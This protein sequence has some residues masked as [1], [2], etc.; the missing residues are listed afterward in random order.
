MTRPGRRR[1]GKYIGAGA[2]DI[3]RRCVQAR[4]APSRVGR[5]VPEHFAHA[6]LTPLND[7]DPDAELLARVGRG[8]PRAVREMV[9]K[10]LGR[11]LSLAERLLGRR[12][13]AEE[14][15]Q[16]VFVRLW[17]QA[18]HWQPGRARFDTWLHRV[19]LNLCYDRLRRRRE[20][21]PDDDADEAAADP[22]DAPD[23]LLQAKQR[24][25]RVARA[26]AELPQRQREAL[27]LQY[28]QE[29]PTAR[30]PS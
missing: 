13:E 3:A 17:K 29:L 6:A 26:L 30:P 11:L 14:V 15:A 18:P 4:Q 8:E 21:A 25:R 27:V 16:E 19:A 22:A 2:T 5:T 10:K 28:Y 7:D 20:E 1:P 24:G 23:A 9:E 12:G